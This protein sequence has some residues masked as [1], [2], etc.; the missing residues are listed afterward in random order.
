MTIENNIEIDFGRNHN[1][2]QKNVDE[3]LNSMI[4]YKK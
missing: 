2:L 1:I 3:T 4:Y